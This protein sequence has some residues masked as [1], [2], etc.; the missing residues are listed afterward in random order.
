MTQLIVGSRAEPCKNEIRPD[1]SFWKL[2]EGNVTA[3]FI[4][5]TRK[6]VR[7]DDEFIVDFVDGVYV[8][9]SCIP[10]YL[11]LGLSRMGTAVP[12]IYPATSRT[13][14]IFNGAASRPSSPVLGMGR[15]Y[16]LGCA[17]C[18]WRLGLRG[19]LAA[20]GKRIEDPAHASAH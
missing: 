19:P 17:S 12:A 18:R 9:V 5:R 4:Q 13:A 16:R 14:S 7:S 11:W 3:D 20:L 15:R 1:S 2:N 6:K 10:G 8:S